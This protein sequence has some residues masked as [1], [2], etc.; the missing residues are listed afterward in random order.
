M[1][2]ALLHKGPL[3]LGELQRKIL[4]SSGGVTYL[5]DRL[6]QR[7]WVRREPCPTDRRAMYAVL[8]KE[9]EALIR[10]IFAGHAAAIEQAE[11]GLSME[12]KGVAIDLLR[13]LGR[14]AAGADPEPARA[15]RSR[16]K[17]PEPGT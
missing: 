4:V 14:A 13:K 8:T 9:G 1:L 11:A 7:G 2:E 16:A 10:E 6:V 12:E 15:R 5:V 17:I 3:L